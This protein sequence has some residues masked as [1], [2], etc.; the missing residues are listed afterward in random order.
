ALAGSTVSRTPLTPAF[1]AAGREWTRSA[2]SS[3]GPLAFAL[4]LPLDLVLSD[5]ADA[6]AGAWASFTPSPPTVTA[7]FPVAATSVSVLPGFG[8]VAF[9]RR[10]RVSRDAGAALSLGALEVR[11]LSTPTL[12][13][14]ASGRSSSF[15]R[16]AIGCAW[17]AK[18]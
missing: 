8:Q 10:S 17:A 18:S 13:I 15:L 3:A 2:T 6:A 1:F 16:A 5:L 11:G 9:F 14:F 4:G 7:A 12:S